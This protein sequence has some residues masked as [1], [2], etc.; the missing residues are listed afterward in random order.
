M[1]STKVMSISPE[2]AAEFLCMNKQNRHLSESVV[3]QYSLAMARGEWEVNGEP[4]IFFDNGLLANGQHRLNAVIKSNKTIDM[5]VVNGVKD[6]TFATIDGG[7]KRGAGDILSIA[8][9]KN[10]IVL[11]SG[12]R[13]YIMYMSKGIKYSNE[14]TS[15][16][17]K[18][19]VDNHPD[20]KY[21]AGEYDSRKSAKLFPSFIVGI[22]AFASEKY[23]IPQVYSFF[24]NITTGANIGE[25]D[26]ALTLRNKFTDMRVKGLQPH[27]SRKAAYIIKALNFHLKGKSI[28]K[29]S[30]SD[31][32]KFPSIV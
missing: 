11:A 9:E 13:A 24:E 3:V 18:K 15:T 5:L 27:V 28:F 21:W 14:I 12:A 6:S 31:G 1:I 29:L 32:E 25:G 7:K 30:F 17:V 2:I 26:P 22:L 10:H 8:G 16:M 4:I 20:L 23:G 19:Y